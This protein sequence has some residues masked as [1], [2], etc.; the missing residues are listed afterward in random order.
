MVLLCASLS[1]LSF[2]VLDDM[3]C[4]E[5]LEQSEVE[6]DDACGIA[7]WGTCQSYQYRH[8]AEGYNCPRMGLACPGW[9]ASW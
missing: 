4:T 8:L 2:Q 6:V 9:S 7:A 1:L 3:I 5:G